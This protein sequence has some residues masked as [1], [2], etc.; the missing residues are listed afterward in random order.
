M[1][2]IIINPDAIP[3]PTIEPIE[4]WV[5]EISILIVIANILDMLAPIIIE[6]IINSSIISP[7]PKNY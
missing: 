1:F 5:P 2:F 6:K 7:L 4:S 3:I